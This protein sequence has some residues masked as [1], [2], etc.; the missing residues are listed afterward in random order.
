VKT[1][2]AKIFKT[3]L[4]LLTFLILMSLLMQT[5]PVAAGE[6]APEGAENL[7][8]VEQTNSTSFKKVS[9]NEMDNE[10]EDPVVTFPDA[11]LEA[12]IRNTIK[13]STGDIYQSELDSIYY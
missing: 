11:G 9:I 13:K 4:T 10:Q 1:L 6:T 7:P 3:R 8:T 12:A 2:Q 5:I